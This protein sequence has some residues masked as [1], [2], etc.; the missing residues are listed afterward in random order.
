MTWVKIKKSF[1]STDEP[2]ITIGNNRFSV[3]SA[4]SKIAELEKNKYVTY[5]VDADD[6]KIAF[7]F[8]NS[9]DADSFKVIIN[10]RKGN[11]SQSTELFTI[12][13]IQKISQQKVINRFKPF[14][15]GK[16]Y[17]IVLMPI[18]ENSVYK[19][20]YLKIPASACGI[21]RYIDNENIVYIGK[22]NIRNRLSELPRNEWKFDRVEYSIITDNDSQLEWESYWI[23]NFKANNQNSLPAYN[24]ISGKL[25]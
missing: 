9:E 21:Y 18:F 12:P 19:K 14:R 1:F 3:N 23:S 5:Y 22:G 24:L 25:G 10:K 16:K 6:R 11:Y 7:E 15:D 13:W 4:F 20:D 8:K 2:L 17:A